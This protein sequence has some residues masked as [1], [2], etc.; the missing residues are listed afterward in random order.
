MSP[1]CGVYAGVCWFVMASL[2]S[3]QATPLPKTDMPVEKPLVDLSIRLIE[4]SGDLELPLKENLVAP[5]T[6][7]GN[8]PK[9]KSAGG[10]AYQTLTPAELANLLQVCQADRRTNILAAPRLRLPVGEKGQLS[11]GVY[12]PYVVPQSENEETIEPDSLGVKKEFFGTAI[13]ATVTIPKPGQLHL[14]LKVEHS[15]LTSQ[16]WEPGQRPGKNTTSVATKLTCASGETV[17]LGGLH[18]ERAGVTVNAIPVLSDL[19]VIGKSFTKV[20][21]EKFSHRLLI[22]V[23]PEL[24]DDAKTP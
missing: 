16:I 12:R 20:K 19:P 11:N 17:V 18:I 23:T 21:H 14:D 9:V 8:E 7:A 24:V 3:A 4:V 22:V 2:A 15:E 10:V 13:D 6:K 1:R 5:P